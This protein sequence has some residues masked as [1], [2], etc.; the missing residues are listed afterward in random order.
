[1]MRLFF[2]VVRV[3]LLPLALCLTGGCAGRPIAD[4]PNIVILLIDT[5]RADHLGCYG[6][7]RNTS[8][9]IDQLASEGVVFENAHAASSWTLPST[10]SMLTSLYPREH[11]AM[12]ITHGISP[13]AVTLAERL[14]QAGYDT[15]AFSAN[16]SMVTVERGFDCGV[17]HF[18]LF[19][20]EGSAVSADVLNRTRK[21]AEKYGE[22]KAVD[23]EE[24][25]SAALKWLDSREDT[26]RPVFMYLH[27][28]DP[29]SPYEPP[30][31]FDTVFDPDYLGTIDGDSIFRAIHMHEFEATERDKQHIVALYDGEI[32]YADSQI[33]DFLD[34]LDKRELLEDALVMI[35]SDHGEELFD[36]ESIGHGPTLYEEVIRVPLIM[37]QKRFERPGTTVDSYVSLVDIVPTVLNVCGIESSGTLRGKPLLPLEDRVSSDTVWA[38]VDEEKLF[39]AHKRALIWNNWKMITSTRRHELYDIVADPRE[40]NNLYRAKKE[41]AKELLSRMDDFSQKLERRMA[42]VLKIDARKLRELESLGYVSGGK[43]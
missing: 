20:K 27:Y 6:Y 39:Y 11:G 8:P 14:R 12:S 13:M 29:H 22:I 35:T 1:V 43:R 26:S 10:A 36:H 2:R 16:Y 7:D 37:W 34:A 42:P 31:P 18:E 28:M 23:A 17:D 25:S 32:A 21:L 15:A 19:V 41:L 5:L 30:P 3:A 40:T 24:L 33:G 38:E 9:E 4:G